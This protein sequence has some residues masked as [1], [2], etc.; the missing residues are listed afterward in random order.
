MIFSDLDIRAADVYG[1]AYAAARSDG[2]DDFEARKRAVL[3]RAVFLGGSADTGSSS[4]FDPSGAICS[5]D[6]GAFRRLSAPT[7]RLPALV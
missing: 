4:R 3:A 6:K 5:E 2:L 1:R 7:H